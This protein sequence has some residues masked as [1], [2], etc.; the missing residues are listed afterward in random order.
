M[1]NPNRRSAGVGRILALLLLALVAASPAWAQFGSIKK[2]LKGK[3]AE[4]GVEQVSPDAAAPTETG[5]AAAGGDN[6]MVVLDAAAVDRLLAGLKAGEA[7]RE[8]ATKEN[9][10]YGRYMQAKAAYQV[11]KPKCDA[12]QATWPNRLAANEK[13]MKKNQALLDK[14]MA[15]M[16]KQD[17]KTQQIYSDS[18]LG[19]VDASC[20][21]KDPQ[22]PSDFWDAKQ[23]LDTRAQQ[24]AE[25]TS[26][27][28]GREFGLVSDRAIAILQDAEVPGGASAAERSAVKAKGPELKAAL[29]IRDAQAERVAKQAPAP[30]PAPVADTAPTPKVTPSS[31]MGAMNACMMAN[32]QKY[33]KELNDLGQK[34]EQASKLGDNATLMAI[35]DSAQKL[36]NHG[37]SAGN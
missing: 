11:A 1:R 24:A 34:A 2:A 19:L 36:Q 16:Q 30:A 7:E 35:A 21:V 17:Q 27:Y 13:L 18:M 4:K 32:A 20:L 14:A 29:G 28:T 25:K 3:A 31:G 33:Q 22:Q 8:K 23:A 12:A 15:A 5:A 26:G 37:C 10:S 9:T 6:S